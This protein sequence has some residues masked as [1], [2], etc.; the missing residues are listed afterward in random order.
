VAEP[1][2]PVFEEFR[3]RAQPVVNWLGVETRR[4]FF[5]DDL[6]FVRLGTPPIDTEYFEWIDLLEAVTRA[7]RHFTMLELGAGYGRWIVNAA[8]ALRLYSGLAATL[9]AVEAEPTHFAWLEEHCRDNAVEA[10][11]IRAA[12]AVEGGEIEFAVGNPA[13]WYGQAIAD[14]SWSPE[15]TARVPAL[16]LSGLL[17][18]YERVDLVHMDV[19]GVEADVLEEARDEVYRVRRFHIGTHGRPQEQRIRNLFTSMSWHLHQDYPSAALSST[20]WGKLRFQ[21][22]LQTW[23]NPSDEASLR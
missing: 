7:S 1:H 18:H 16:T 6:E 22:G 20:P 8:R 3:R 17:S 21:D 2:H 9:V 14:G 11:L 4:S 13:G 23:V 10:D 12:V 5:D 15:Q 19:Q